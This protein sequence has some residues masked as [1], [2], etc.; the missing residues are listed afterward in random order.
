MNSGSICSMTEKPA[1]AGAKKDG[2]VAKKDAHGS[3]PFA[4]WFGRIGTKCSYCA[5]MIGGVAVTGGDV[6]VLAS[7]IAGDLLVL[8]AQRGQ[9]PLQAQPRRSGRRGS[10]KFTASNTSPWSREFV[11]GF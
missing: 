7:E 3:V 1:E 11:G 6:V 10:G 5:P 2:G 8:D 9:G 4:C